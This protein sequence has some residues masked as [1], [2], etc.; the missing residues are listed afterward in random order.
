MEADVRWKYGVTAAGF[1]GISGQV[2]LLR[3]LEVLFSGN[4]L[5]LGFFFAGWLLWSA[6]GAG[7]AVRLF[8]GKWFYPVLAVQP[9]VFLGTIWLIR[10]WPLIV[11]RP[12]G[13]IFG[14]VDMAIGSILLITPFA[15]TTG[16][17]FTLGIRFSGGPPR[18]IYLLEAAGAAMG[19]ILAAVMLGK[20]NPFQFAFLVAGINLIISCRRVGFQS[21][22]AFIS[23]IG[24]AWGGGV[25]E[26]VSL[27]AFWRGNNIVRHSESVYSDIAVSQSEGQ[28][29][30][31]LSG[32][33][34]ASYPA[35]MWAEETVHFP[36]LAHPFPRKILLIGGGLSGAV[37][38]I[39]KYSSVEKLYYAEIDNKLLNITA[40]ALPKEAVS[41]IND[42]RVKIIDMDGRAW[43]KKR[44][45]NYDVV[46]L[47]AP[48]PLSS[49]INRYYTAEF[50]RE[51]RDVMSKGGVFGF[52]LESSEVFI[53]SQRAEF[54]AGMRRTL[55]S[56]FHNTALFP[57]GRCQ[58]LAGRSFDFDAYQLSTL[59]KT[60]GVE[61]D[62]VSPYFLP[63]RLSAD[64]R[65]YLRRTLD[66]TVETWINRDFKPQAYISA[67]ERWERQFH[68]K[69]TGAYNYIMKLKP[70]A[71]ILF[72]TI[73]IVILAV[74]VR[75]DL[76]E[77]GVKSAVALGGFAQIS[78]QIMLILGFQSI[79]G[80]MYYQQAL[81]ITAFMVGAAGGCYCGGWWDKY[82]PD[83][84][85]RGL[86]LIQT[87]LIALPLFILALLW[88]NLE[89]GGVSRHLLTLGA[90][91]CGGIG[92][93]QYALASETVKGDRA[94]TGGGLYALDLLGSS[95]GALT[96]GLILVT[97]WGTWSA[98]ILLAGLAVIP[99]VLMLVGGGIQST[100]RL[101]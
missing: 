56:V 40:S 8:K 85:R 43:V 90:L 95:L 32:L 6:A 71:I 54:L 25:M 12:A 18:R 58:F 1:G 38:E 96:A 62:F 49:R 53:D 87:V 73:F 68:P 10:L 75:G 21:A 99:L 60:R 67:L 3:Q 101:E 59:L 100:E 33:L 69:F 20:I 52:N 5:S 4:E 45:E 22:A 89:W 2:V 64:R 19:G 76:F 34:S 50:F 88:L 23:L 86:A 97:L 28:Y 55:A 63:S 83:T 84:R 7:L 42:A 9:L 93:L 72:F 80:Y 13:L 51:V 24:F 37:E 36:M 74:S 48:E 65:G 66:N 31:F 47:G 61:T 81:L 16:A 98:G 91:L 78:L 11:G 77:R 14:P 70:L 15:F 29:S 30:I 27:K 39:L 17:L 46:I 82:S 41:W 35:P 44:G 94:K 92:G 57:G 79:Y 26:K